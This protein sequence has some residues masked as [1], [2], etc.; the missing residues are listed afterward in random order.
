MCT[1]LPAIVLSCALERHGSH[2]EM[3]EEASNWRARFI[4]ST[5]TSTADGPGP[6]F[7]WQSQCSPPRSDAHTHL[8]SP[9]SCVRDAGPHNGDWVEQ[10]KVRATRCIGSYSCHSDP[11]QEIL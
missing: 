8:H 10:I 11:S 4:R 7:K 6:P 5:A 2:A 9:L 1:L 3:T